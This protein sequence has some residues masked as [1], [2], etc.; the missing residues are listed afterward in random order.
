MVQGSAAGFRQRHAEVG[1]LLLAYG[2]A[3][4]HVDPPHV[5]QRLCQH[6]F[7]LSMRGGGI[8]S[9]GNRALLEHN[10]CFSVKHHMVSIK[11]GNRLNCP[12]FA[13]V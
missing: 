4:V 11:P 1:L 3:E 6:H 2:I 9:C 13:V 5:A 10:M 8:T 12:P 7:T